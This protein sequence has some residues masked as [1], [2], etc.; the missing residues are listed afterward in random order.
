MKKLAVSSVAF[1]TIFA[2]TLLAYAQP[3]RCSNETL[4][5]PTIE[6]DLIVPDGGRCQINGG[7]VTGNVMVGRQAI[8]QVTTDGYLRIGGNVQGE[9]CLALYLTS[10]SIQGNVHVEGC[11]K[12]VYVRRISIGGNGQFERNTSLTVL[13]NRI[14]G[15][16]LCEGNTVV[17]AGYN[18][19][20]G[21]QSGQCR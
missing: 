18:N 8:L 7:T 10:A 6:G 9:S 2:S 11:T 1:G 13:D 3:I 21:R 14:L 19:V 5:N 4:T 17:N 16:L 20:G 12:T 15:N